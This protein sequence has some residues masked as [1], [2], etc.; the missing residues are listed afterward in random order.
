[1]VVDQKNGDGLKPTN[2]AAISVSTSS[3]VL[4]SSSIMKTPDA[5]RPAELDLSTDKQSIKTKPSVKSKS[6]A[7][8]SVNASAVVNYQEMSK[9]VSPVINPLQTKAVSIKKEQVHPV[10]QSQLKPQDETSVKPQGHIHLQPQVSTMIK[11]LPTLGESQIH[12]QEKS[13]N[14]TLAMRASLQDALKSQPSDKP[15]IQ[16]QGS[17]L[18]ATQSKS[19]VELSQKKD[20]HDQLNLKLP[21]FSQGL[22]IHGQTHP[23]STS[24]LAEQSAFNIKD[25]AKPHPEEDESSLRKLLGLA[26]VPSNDKSHIQ[27]QGH[28]QN[29]T[30]SNMNTLHGQRSTVQNSQNKPHIQSHIKSIAQQTGQGKGRGQILSHAHNQTQGQPK[31]SSFRPNQLESRIQN[32][33]QSLTH[34]Q[35]QLQGQLQGQFHIAG[36]EDQG[37]PLSQI[38]SMSPSPPRV[39]T[40][41]N[42][43]QRMQAPFSSPTNINKP[44]A[45]GKTILDLLD[46]V[47]PPRNTQTFHSPESRPLSHATAVSSPL[48]SCSFQNVAQQRISPPRNIKATNSMA[49]SSSPPLSTPNMHPIRNVSPIRQISN[50][51]GTFSNISPQKRLSSC[52]L[53]NI[54]SKL[55]QETPPSPRS[56]RQGYNYMSKV[57]S[58]P[59]LSCQFP[60]QSARSSPESHQRTSHLNT[61]ASNYM[62]L[63]SSDK[64]NAQL[65]AT[66]LLNSIVK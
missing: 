23:L 15:L 30:A 44:K 66:S 20:S 17:G 35:S 61:L 1:M 37:H 65:T 9:D 43:P 33:M 21:S 57:P 48:S 46:E 28:L 25:K 36:R 26:E 51:T 19:Q 27:L 42:S 49:V 45:T 2:L 39:L 13:P 3:N 38:Q 63:S 18:M 56:P 24:Q 55:N 34:P 32:Q 12:T 41:N 53:Q 10:G 50:N 14:E 29:Q 59:N 62:A 4:K 64:A 7:N 58:S 47:S 5:V 22:P 6:E 16:A 8:V 11:S 40:H 52:S 54:P 31:T 60:M